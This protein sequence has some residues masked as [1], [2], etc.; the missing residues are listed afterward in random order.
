MIIMS[1]SKGI[2]RN[3]WSTY[4]LP[5]GIFIG[6]LHTPPTIS[7]KETLPFHPCH[8]PEIVSHKMVCKRKQSLVC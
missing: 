4:I 1:A 7:V 2:L 6:L 3:N 8:F 5:F